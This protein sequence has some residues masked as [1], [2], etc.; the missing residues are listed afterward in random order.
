MIEWCVATN[1]EQLM[2][3]YYEL[4]NKETEEDKH[5]RKPNQNQDKKETKDQSLVMKA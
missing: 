3:T 5:K 2:K 1:I 4:G